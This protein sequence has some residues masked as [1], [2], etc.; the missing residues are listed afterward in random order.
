MI[1]TSQGIKR[2]GHKMI[3]KTTCCSKL[4]YS[5]G[6]SLKK[7][8]SHGI[9]YTKGGGNERVFVHYVRHTTTVL[10]IY[11]FECTYVISIWDFLHIEDHCL[12]K[13]APRKNSDEIWKVAGG[14]WKR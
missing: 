3:W 5:R 2:A 1:T 8:C 6:F 10:I 9:D 7:R 4:E 11:F 14:R 12:N 13:W